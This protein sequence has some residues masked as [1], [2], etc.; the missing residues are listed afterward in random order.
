MNLSLLAQQG[1][2][3]AYLIGVE[4]G[5]IRDGGQ[6]GVAARDEVLEG[7]PSIGGLLE[8]ERDG[9]GPAL[10]DW[11]V[12]NAQAGLGSCLHHAA[13][14]VSKSCTCEPGQSANR[15]GMACQPRDVSGKLRAEALQIGRLKD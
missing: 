1:P 3:K 10:P 12:F 2:R 8:P 5:V 4:D 13:L 7:V 11:E 14:S 9:K 6:A 15:G